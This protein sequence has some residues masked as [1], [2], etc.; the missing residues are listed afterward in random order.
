VSAENEDRFKVVIK[1]EKYQVLQTGIYRATLV[2]IDD[3]MG[4]FDQPIFKLRFRIHDDNPNARYRLVDGFINKNEDGRY[5]KLWQLKKAFDHRE[6][7]EGERIDIKSF[8]MKE[9]YIRVER[10]EHK[11]AITEYIPIGH[12]NDIRGE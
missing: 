10:R 6:C 12:L 2:W 7:P 9:C 11:N 5:G 8:Y 3:G 1:R 4:A